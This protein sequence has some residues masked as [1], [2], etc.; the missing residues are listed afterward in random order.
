M[1][2]QIEEEWAKWDYSHLKAKQGHRSESQ[3]RKVYGFFMCMF[4]CLNGKVG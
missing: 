2:Q 3:Q 4:V 1:E